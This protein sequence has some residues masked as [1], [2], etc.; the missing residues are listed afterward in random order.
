MER[1]NS[2]SVKILKK[3]LNFLAHTINM[4]IN[5]YDNRYEHLKQIKI[6]SYIIRVD[7]KVLKM[8]S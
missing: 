5:I 7:K 3:S 2:L 8:K 6:V 1:A 4:K